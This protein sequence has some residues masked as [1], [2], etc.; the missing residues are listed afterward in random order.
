MNRDKIMKIL[1]GYNPGFPFTNEVIADEILASQWISVEDE[2]PEENEVVWCYG[3]GG[4]LGDYK[5]FSAFHNG[6]YWDRLNYG[7]HNVTHWQ[8]LP[9]PPETHES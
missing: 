9:A 6:L 7:R 1:D 3:N 2:L 4:C 8:P 5:M